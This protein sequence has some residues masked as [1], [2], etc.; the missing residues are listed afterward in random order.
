VVRTRLHRHVERGAARTLAGLVERDDLAVAAAR[1]GRALADD[2]AVADDDG[3]DRGLRVGAAVGFGGQLESSG[4]RHASAGYA[5]RIRPRFREGEVVR[6]PL[7]EGVVD[8]VAGPTEDGAGWAILLRIGDELWVLP[9]DDLEAVA[10][11]TDPPSERVDSLELRLVTELADGVEA[12]R[13]ADRVDDGVRAVVGPSILTIVAERHWAEPY[14]YEFDV[15]VRPLGDAVEALRAL[16]AA[17]GDRWLSCRD[18]GWRCELWWHAEE[19]EPGF[20][21]PEVRGAEVSFLPWSSPA[22]RP[23]GERPLVSV[24][25]AR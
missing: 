10:A 25:G 16:V 18:D 15:S 20:L 24:S 17:G 4:D 7:G 12:A 21:V 5:P 23:E 3:A 2:H 8:D 19:H 6:S 14:F 13:V 11:Q 1:L 22:L 9:E